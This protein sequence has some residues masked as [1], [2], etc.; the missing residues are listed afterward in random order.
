MHAPPRATDDS[1]DAWGV[2]R[3]RVREG[4]EGGSCPSLAR[5]GVLRL[6]VKI[7]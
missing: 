3:R 1:R 2:G 7:H 4:V 6:R 5:P